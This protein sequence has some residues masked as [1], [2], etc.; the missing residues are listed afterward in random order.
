MKIIDP[1]T[2][3]LEDLYFNCLEDW[4]A[5]MAESGNHKSRWYQRMQTK[6]LGV[7]LALTDNG[8]VGGMIQYCPVEHSF[9]E[10]TELYFILCIWVHNYDVGVGRLQGQGLGKALL[11]AAEADARTHGKQGM[12]AWGL[13]APFWMPATW[14]QKHGY[15]PVDKDKFRVLLLKAFDSDA[16]AP[17]WIHPRKKPKQ[18]PGQVTVTAFLNGWC[19]SMNIVFE[20]AKSAS[21]AFD[22][23]VVFKQI[24]TFDRTTFLEWGISDA[25]YIDGIEIGS[26]PP[27]SYEQIISE[28]A[29]R[30]ALLN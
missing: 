2:P 30:V 26:G 18:I 13:D 28:I 19:S 22:E 20:R 16:A 10:G 24:D 29:K 15:Q 3:E 1:T 6:G 8:Q 23:R 17:R 7:K 14:F 21:A 4:S 27:L 12:A 11:E 5:E 9:V 25:V